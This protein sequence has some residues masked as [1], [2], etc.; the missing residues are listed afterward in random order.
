MPKQKCD[1]FTMCVL[2][3]NVYL[4]AITFCCLKNYCNHNRKFR[5]HLS[6]LNYLTVQ[7]KKKH[8]TVFFYSKFKKLM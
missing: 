7:R 8:K 5:K 3:S 1:Y 6:T 2:A 4:N